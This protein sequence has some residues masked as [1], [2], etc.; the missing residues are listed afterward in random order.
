M[1]RPPG[2]RAPPAATFHNLWQA[3]QGP[4]T[5]KL[6]WVPTQSPIWWS[7]PFPAC[8]PSILALVPERP[9][10]Q[11]WET[12]K[13]AGQ[14]DPVKAQCSE[15]GG[16]AWGQQGALSWQWGTPSRLLPG[17]PGGR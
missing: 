2:P 12:P 6:S 5:S 16:K 11:E 14:G 13:A 15:S 8:S 9:C 7:P 4:L 17:Q 3:A 1:S 10:L